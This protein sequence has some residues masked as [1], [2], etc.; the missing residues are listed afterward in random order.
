MAKNKKRFS[1]LGCLKTSISCI[2]WD[3][4]PIPCL[5]VK[6]GDMLDEVTFA[7][8]RKL[9]SALSDSDLMDLNIQCL[10]DKLQVVEPSEKTIPVFLQMLIDNDCKLYDLIEDVRQLITNQNPS[11]V[12]NLK[13]LAVLDDFGNQLPYTEQTVLQSLI[14]EVCNTRTQISGIGLQIQ[15][16]NETLNNLPGPYSEPLINPNC[17]HSQPKT[18]SISYNILASDYCNYKGKVG[19]VVQIETSISLQPEVTDVADPL[20]N[21]VDLVPNPLSMAE[22]NTNQWVFIK[23][24]Y[25]RILHLESCACQFSCKDIIV[26]FIVVFNE[27]QTATLKFTQGAGNYIPTGFSD[28]GSILTIKNQNGVT[29]NQIL[30]NIEQDAQIDGI[31][32]SMFSNGDILTFNIQ[33]K[34]CNA[35][36]KFNCDKCVSKTIKYYSGGCCTIDNTGDVPGILIYSYCP[37]GKLV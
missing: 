24:L 11:L 15:T 31:D 4:P 9:C 16:I 20:F 25:Q 28:C 21:N 7:I 10:I 6:T 29:S 1:S 22:D 17:F 34:L 32:V 18:L 30:I 8:V 26:A 33:A 27:D 13:C 35:T 14:N 5:G 36:T 3:L 23:S 12:L 37:A 2:E 19:T